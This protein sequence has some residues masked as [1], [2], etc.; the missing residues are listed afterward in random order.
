MV[1]C[2][3]EKDAKGTW[4]MVVRFA[5]FR[6]LLDVVYD[7]CVQMPGGGEGIGARNET[8]RQLMRDQAD[9]E[10]SDAITQSIVDQSHVRF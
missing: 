3:V 7:A 2:S 9:R 10:L 4:R 1:R 5:S 8:L 6:E